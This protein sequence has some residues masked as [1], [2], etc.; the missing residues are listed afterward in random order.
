MSY[1]WKHKVPKEGKLE[2]V[3]GD[4]GGGK[5][6][7]VVEKIYCALCLGAFVY[8]NIKF[9]IAFLAAYM[10][11][12]EN[13]VFDPARLVI[14]TGDSMADFHTQIKRGSPGEVVCVAIDEA[15]FDFSARN[16]REVE[17]ETIHFC[18]LCRKLHVWLMFITQ[19]GDNIANCV[20]KI[21][22]VET[23]CRNTK[24][25]KFLG[26]EF[27][28][29]LYTRTSYKLRKGRAGHRLEGGIIKRP[30]SWGMYDSYALLGK[31]AAVFENLEVAKRSPLAQAVK[32]SGGLGYAVAAIVVVLVI[33]WP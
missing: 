5:T 32:G 1:A 3:T 14:L 24:E 18:T 20:R 22:T 9:D 33:T 8:T 12:W 4:L 13:L 10:L 17:D 11:K 19:D 23:V 2:L 31:Q 6:A 16:A 26:F 15:H 30:F 28:V 25:E 27:P 29:E 7:L 21:F